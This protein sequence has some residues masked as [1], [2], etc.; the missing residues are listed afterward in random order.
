MFEIADDNNSVKEFDYVSISYL[1][2]LSDII[3]W[4]FISLYSTIST[5]LNRAS[6]PTVRLSRTPWPTCTHSI[7]L[8]RRQRGSV[9]YNAAVVQNKQVSVV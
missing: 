1:F 3:Y 9:C 6:V 5:W 4:P 2:S 8:C 7:T